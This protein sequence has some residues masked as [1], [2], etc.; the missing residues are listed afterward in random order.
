[1][2]S[3]ILAAAILAAAASTAPAAVFVYNRETGQ[4]VQMPDSAAPATKNAHTGGPCGCEACDCKAC[5]CLDRKALHSAEADASPR[6]PADS[7]TAAAA[8]PKAEAK[9]RVRYDVCNGRS[10]TTYEVNEGDPIP[11]GA[12]NVRFAPPASTSNASPAAAADT[13]FTAPADEYTER[14]GIIGRILDNCKAR[15][16]GRQ[17]ARAERGGIFGRARGASCASCGQ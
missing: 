13:S 8:A 4:V 7:L 2:R 9:R 17:A 3:F 1:M 10:C 12:S 16:E 11:A 5:E 15:R 6:D 14:R